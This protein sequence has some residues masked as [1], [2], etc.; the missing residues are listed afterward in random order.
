MARVAQVRELIFF[1][2]FLGTENAYLRAWFKSQ[3][4][5][6][7]PISLGMIYLL[8]KLR[9][10]KDSKSAT[11]LPGQQASNNEYNPSLGCSPR[12]SHLYDV[13]D[14]TIATGAHNDAILF[15]LL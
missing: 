7:Y 9:Y 10:T 15:F 11:A 6:F 8:F 14:R 3:K 5:E 4:F 1:I 13:G 12:R 2:L